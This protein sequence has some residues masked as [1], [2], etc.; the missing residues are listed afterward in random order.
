M[1]RNDKKKLHD[2]M[3]KIRESGTKIKKKLTKNDGNHQ[4]QT[5]K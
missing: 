5:R 1:E 2:K 4:K 3:K